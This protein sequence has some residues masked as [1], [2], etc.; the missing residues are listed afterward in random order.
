MRAIVDTNALIWA[1]NDGGQLSAKARHRLND[2]ATVKVVSVVVFWEMAIKVGLGKL[3]LGMAPDRLMK[4]LVAQGEIELLAIKAHH[5]GRLL[6]LPLHHRDPF[7]RLMI[8]QALE[9]GWEVVSSDDQWD[10]YGVRRIW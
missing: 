2:P 7:D 4:T 9:E 6:T 8:A 1:T 3:E 5:L 10:A